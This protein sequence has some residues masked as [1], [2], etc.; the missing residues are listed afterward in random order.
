MGKEGKGKEGEGREDWAT[1]RVEQIFLF[2]KFFLCTWCLLYAGRKH[3]PASGNDPD[4]NHETIFQ[5]I[6]YSQFSLGGC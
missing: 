6:C 3:P 5:V 2:Y 4:I 1:A